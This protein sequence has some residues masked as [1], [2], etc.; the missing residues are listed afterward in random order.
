MQAAAAA[1]IAI[2]IPAERLGVDLHMARDEIDLVGDSLTDDILLSRFGIT[3][4]ER[5]NSNLTM[6]LTG[7]YAWAS[8][9][10]QPLT[11]GMRFTGGYAGISAHGLFPLGQHF[12]IGLDGGILYHFLYDETEDQRVEQDLIEADAALTLQIVLSGV[13]TLYGGPLW[14]S[15]ELDQLASGAVNSTTSF[16]NSDSTGAV[17]GVLYEIEY[18]GWVGLEFRR[19]PFDGAALSFQRGF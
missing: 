2:G 3:L 11:A 18:Q 5:F 14:S 15:I 1:D 19:G 17:V 6:Q 7:G 16:E 4:G 12:G 9:F 13:W 10:D 8:D